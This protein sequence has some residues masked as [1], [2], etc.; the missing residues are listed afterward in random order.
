MILK[1][2]IV[3]NKINDLDKYNMILFYG[4]NLGLINDF[5]SKLKKKGSDI[6]NFYQ[7]EL[8]KNEN[9]L[10]NEIMNISLFNK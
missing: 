10:I 8:L 6:L 7:D 1:S 4:E 2:Y 3:E 5:K 9:V